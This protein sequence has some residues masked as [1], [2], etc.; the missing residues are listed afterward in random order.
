[1][2]SAGK[3]SAEPCRAPA[4]REGPGT[5]SLCASSPLAG[6]QEGTGH[7]L[8]PGTAGGREGELHLPSHADAGLVIRFGHSQ[9]P[10]SLLRLR[11]QAEGISSIFRC[12]AVVGYIKVGDF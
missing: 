3:C 4:P 9:V 5:S 11:V 7:F 10:E 8:G 6:A 12:A 1:M 2:C